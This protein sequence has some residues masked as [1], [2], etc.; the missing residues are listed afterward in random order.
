M[1]PDGAAVLSS[2]Q[3]LT[4]ARWLSPAFPT[5]GFAWSHG[6]EQAARDGTV[7]DAATLGD[8]LGDV[9]RHG[10]GRTDAIL[11]GAAH[12]ASEDDLAELAELATALAPSRERRAEAAGQGAAFARTLRALHAWDLPDAPFPVVLGRAARLGGLPA[13]PVAEV[14]LQGFVTTLAQAAQRL[15]PLGQTAAQGVVLRLAP[16]CAEVAEAVRLSPDDIGS[17]AVAVDIAS[18]RHEG[19]EPRIFRS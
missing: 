9:L 4:L 14:A 11:I 18:L 5:G 8:W 6:L 15:M 3:L 13:R 17:C 7:R 19:L 1:S 16:V 10:A 12:R 2:A